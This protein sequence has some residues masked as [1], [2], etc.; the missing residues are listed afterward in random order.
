MKKNILVF[1]LLIL[2]FILNLYTD[3]VIS[4]PELV[5]PSGIAV[6][7][8]KFYIS[9]EAEVKIYSLKGFKFIKKFGKKGEGPGEFMLYPGHG[10]NIELLNNKLMINSLGKITFF[11]EDGTYINEIRTGKQVSLKY[12]DGKYIGHGFEIKGKVNYYNLRLFNSKF[13]KIKDLIEWKSPIQD[14]KFEIDMAPEYA[15]YHIMNDKIYANPNSEFIIDIFN[16]NGIK[17]NSI[18]YPYSRIKIDNSYKKT[19]LAF[20]KTDK[21]WKNNFA[22]IKKAGKFKTFFPAIKMLFIDEK[23]LYVQTYKKHKDQCE[24][25][26]FNLNGKFIKKV[27]VPFIDSMGINIVPRHTIKNGIMYQ[28]VENDENENWDL[29]V[30]EF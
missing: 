2:L 13:K 1:L 23:R 29:K 15:G 8:T 24:F 18:I 5:N 17:I 7:N 3:T 16:K 10:V 14:V 12:I 25:L 27:F 11:K 6:S 26:L 22:L 28:L 30:Y 20:F 9:D 19:V 4:I 21:R